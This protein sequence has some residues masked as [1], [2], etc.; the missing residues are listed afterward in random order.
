[1]FGERGDMFSEPI[2][3]GRGGIEIVF[4]DP[5]CELVMALVFGIAHRFEE[6]CVA[7]GAADVFG[8]ASS[9]PCGSSSPVR[10]ENAPVMINTRRPAID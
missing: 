3:I 10:E 1:V 5:V 2:G 7:E 8:R 4:V 9:D 6:L